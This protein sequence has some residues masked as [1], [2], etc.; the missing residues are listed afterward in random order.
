MKTAIAVATTLMTMA[1]D[2]QWV[3]AAVAAVCIVDA[4]VVSVSTK[5]I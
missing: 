5:L 1:I 3:A 2:G 4:F